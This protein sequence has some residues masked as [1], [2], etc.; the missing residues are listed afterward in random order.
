MKKLFSIFGAL[1]L[2]LMLTT[3]AH[4]A[5]LIQNGGFEEPLV[6]NVDLWQ[7]F[8]ETENLPWEISGTPDEGEPL[9]AL[10]YHKSEIYLGSTAAEG[11]Q[12]VELDGYYPVRISQTIQACESGN[13]QVSFQYAPR[14]NHPENKIKVMF[15]GTQIL[16]DTLASEEPFAWKPFSQE[17]SGPDEGNVVLSFEETGANDQLGM[18]LDNVSVECKAI[19][20][21]EDDEVCYVPG[22]SEFASLVESASQGLQKD[23][24]AVAPGRSTPTQGLVFEDAQDESS[25]YSLGFGGS[26]VVEFTNIFVDAPSANDLKITEDTW[27]AYPLEQAEI[28][29]SQNGTD[30]RL[31]GVA[32]NT[33]FAGIHTTTEF[34]LAGSGLDWAKYVKIEDISDPNA[35]DNAGDGYDLNAV[36]ALSGGRIVPCDEEPE[37]PVYEGGNSCPTGTVE[38]FVD[39]WTISSTEPSPID[40]GLTAGQYLF[41]ASGS[42]SYGTPSKLADAGYATADTWANLRSDIGITGTNRGVTSLLSDMGSG[43]MGIVDWGTYDST[44]HTYNFLYTTTGNPVK[45]VISDWWSDWYVSPYNNQGAMSDNSGVLTLD[46]YRCVEETVEDPGCTLTQGYWKNHKSE[47]PTAPEGTDFSNFFG[48]GKR[49]VAVL[50]TAPAG[51]VYY[52]LAHQYIAAKLNVLN[53]ADDTALGTAL[54][55]AEELFNTTPKEA[56]KLKGTARTEWITLAGILADYNQGKTGPG[57]CEEEHQCNGYPCDISCGDDSHDNLVMRNT[58]TQVITTASAVANTGG[59]VGANQTGNGTANASAN[60]QVNWTSFFRRR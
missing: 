27:G 49:Y 7:V 23:G 8:T 55:D 42:Y 41:R 46:V 9:E 37:I 44:N 34:D 14:P 40:V 53:G 51:N 60:A 30:W 32:N 45:F 52:Q 43:V 19:E 47:W 16:D 50:R 6:T 39:D 21:P 58:N 59:N 26:I 35:F 13:Y 12:Y 15:D 5:N 17:V 28:S 31:L 3:P 4:A 20:E 54:A 24:N 18:F 2:A 22:D 57:H 33:N 48:T 38:E 25:F 56:K 11:D 10:E 1:V 29:I 36:E